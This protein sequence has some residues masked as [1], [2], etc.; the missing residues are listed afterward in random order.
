MSEPFEI[1]SV[2]GLEILDSRGHPTLSVSVRLAGG[3]SAS[4]SV[5]SGASVGS[6]EA[7]ELRDKAK[8]YGGRG[9]LRAVGH[10]NDELNRLLNGRDARDQRGVDEAMCRADG[11]DNK[12]RLGANALLGASLAVARAAARQKQQPLHRHI[13]ELFETPRGCLPIP[14]MN[15]INGGVHASNNLD[16]Q[17][18]MIQPVD[19]TSFSEALRQC[20]EV[21]HALRAW[22]K[23]HA[24]TV[25]V[26]DEGGF[27]PD[28]QSNEAALEALVVAVEQAGLAPGKQM[29]LALDCA[30][31]EFYTD[32]C[33][34]LQA[35]GARHSA[36]EFVAYLEKLCHNFPI[37]SVEDGVA[38]DDWNGWKYLSERLGDKVQLVGD[39][40]FVTHLSRLQKGIRENVANA[41]LVKLNQIGTLSETLDVMRC[42]RDSGYSTVVS[43]RSGETEDTTIADLAVGTA[44]GQ[45]KTGAPA[46]SDRV[47][48]YNRLLSI[49][50]HMAGEISLCS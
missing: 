20:V 47:A 45:I 21:Y 12:S 19:A 16:I 11:T 46:R 29:R 42:A 13:A 36:R 32:G 44:A 3:T 26:G 23:Q 7:V 8:R 33:Y 15:I 27:A 48:K 14:M 43:H 2:E 10:V 38:E 25:A 30:A 18:F 37:A 6:F 4:A 5:P 28:L 50:A 22:L 39:D 1:S 40:L 35:E 9:V 34:H 24:H 31:N 49:E 41:I 17:E